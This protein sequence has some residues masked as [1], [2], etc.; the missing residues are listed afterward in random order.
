MASIGA[1]LCTFVRGH[2]PRVKTRLELWRVPGLN[3][4]GAL[5]LGQND[6]EFEFTAVCYSS[7]MGVLDWKLQIEALQGQIV[8]IINDL[9]ITYSNC[10][11]TKLGNLRSAAALAP[12]GIT[13]RG[14]M[15]IGGVVTQ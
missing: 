14:E 15:Q 11:I 5:V 12:G 13:Q 8:S 4:Y 10:L 7:A 9:G 3:G 1:V 6:S 2:A